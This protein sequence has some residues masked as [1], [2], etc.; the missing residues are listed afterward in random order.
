LP[1]LDVLR[2]HH[3]PITHCNRW[4]QWSDTGVFVRMMVGLDAEAAV[5]T[6]VTIHATVFKGHRT[7]SSLRSEKGDL[8]TN[9]AA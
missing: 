8:A 4:T 6:T 2:E 9:G 3:P 1:W 5:P 7:A